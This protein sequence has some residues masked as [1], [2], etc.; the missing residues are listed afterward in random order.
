MKGLRIPTL[1]LLN[2]LA[3]TTL[4]RGEVKVRFE[5]NNNDEAT[6]AFRFGSIP[7]P[8]KGNA[9][10]DSTVTLVDGNPDPNGGKASVLTDG[11]VP[12]DED[13]PSANFF[14][15]AGSD[16]GR[17]R[18]DLGRT[19][20]I[21][22]V[23]TFS[24]H[25]GTRG[26]QVY[27]LYGAVG[28][29]SPLE[30]QPKR[31]TDPA[32]HGWKFLASVD[33][34]PASG[35]MGGQYGVCVEE[36]SGSLGRFRYL[37]FDIVATEKN[38]PFGNTFYSE[39]DIVDKD[40]PALLE[41]QSAQAPVV[42]QVIEMEGGKYRITLDT[43]E[44]P[45]LT[46]WAKEQLVPMAREWY[47]RLVKML[48][49]E[50]Y[51]APARV[52]IVISEGMSGVAETGGT[53]IRCA[54]GWFRANL[55]GEAVGAVLH[56][57]VHVAQQYD[58]VEANPGHTRPPGW[59]VEGIADYIRWFHFEPQAHGAEIPPSRAPQAKYDASYRVTANFLNWAT[60]KYCRELVPKLNAAVRQ[61]RYSS[62]IWAD[63]TTHSLEELGTEW[64]ANLEKGAPQ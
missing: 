14:F 41:T 60:G 63:L 33:T 19:I 48:P 55:K 21:Q 11:Q 20:A 18:I 32:A 58:G 43:T 36:S 9:A 50:G 15:A 42:Q 30:S 25:P 16:G 5:N 39:I 57:L 34:R 12:K 3:V 62:K 23:N 47:P 2:C 8:Q 24:W 4:S 1:V 29:D 37:L 44:T 7:A 28:Q 51:Q 17:V 31:G 10:R 59:L 53:R 13:Q 56:E 46:K 52:S 38:D 49:S 40:A 45:D 35:E 26:P 27:R 64:K 22:Q 54:A 61:H 6:R